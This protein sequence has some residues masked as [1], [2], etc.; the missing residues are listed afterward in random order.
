M[1]AQ[2]TQSNFVNGEY[3]PSNGQEFFSY[4]PADESV[5][6]KCN[7]ADIALV[8]KAIQGAKAAQAAWGAMKPTERG[9]ILM[10]AAR[11]IREN[12]QELSELESLDT[13]KAI[14]ETLVADAMSG[15]DCLEYFGGIIAGITSDYIELGGNFAYTRRE[16]LGICFGI[17][18]WNY[19]IQ[20]ACWKS[21]PAL[22]AGN[23]MIFKPASNT[24]LSALKLAEIY[25]KAG[26]PAGLFQ[27]IQGDRKIAQYLVE[28]PDIAK[29]SL[30][31]SVATGIKVMENAAKG[32]KKIT[33]ELGGK[34]P[35]I[36]MPS[37]N[38]T[39]AV[40]GAMM[41]NF[42][43]TG[44]VCTNGTRVFVHE[45]LK[46]AF[47][48]E[49]KARTARIKIGDSLNPDTQMGPLVSK[50]QYD[51]VMEYIAIGKGEANLLHGGKRPDG[52]AKGWFVEPTIFTECQD[53]NRIVQEEIFGP[54]MSVLDFKDE[55]EVIARAN[56]CEMGLA[57]AVF[58]QNINEAHRMV[59]Q[60][61]AG[62]IWINNY[63]LTPIEMPFGGYKLSGI[64][65][66]N[67]KQALDYYSQIKAI[68]VE[69]GSVVAPF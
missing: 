22:A 67:A 64:G 40:S 61:Q 1:R 44:Q 11:L 31:G 32:L 3:C 33:L 26:L 69:T 51:S 43:S 41:A 20:I 60:I 59:A 57:G 15:A 18:A 36:I 52:F 38:I 53:K 39:D 2:P 21:A 49:L 6:A 62:T 37:A 48:S 42:Y 45:S 56:E 30:T 29:V 47:L 34:S 12:N 5:I 63:N 35:L 65:R 28:H 66:E 55:A 9:K 46:N 54:V 50:A 17:G 14:Q 25:S 16:P 68:F 27:V 19:P 7:Y 8:D 24:P 10:N 13:G 58:T 23:A 4:Y